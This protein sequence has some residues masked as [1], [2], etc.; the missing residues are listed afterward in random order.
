[1]RPSKASA[2]HI[3]VCYLILEKVTKHQ[4]QGPRRRSA[5]S[6][7][8]AKLKHASSSPPKSELLIQETVAFPSTQRGRTNKGGQDSCLP[9][10]DTVGVRGRALAQGE[11]L[12][13]G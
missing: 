11:V 8:Q 7:K 5:L 3:R 4:C 12:S 2:N 6:T 9:V 10:W 13:D 1:M